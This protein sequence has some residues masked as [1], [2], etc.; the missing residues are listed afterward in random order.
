MVLAGGAIARS[1]GEWPVEIDV[2]FGGAIVLDDQ[3][4]DAT[5]DRGCQ[6]GAFRMQN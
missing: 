1:F 6:I 4:F 3:P 2:D 5:G